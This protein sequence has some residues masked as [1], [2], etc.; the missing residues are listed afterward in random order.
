M[1]KMIET[2]KAIGCAIGQIEKS[3]ALAVRDGALIVATLIDGIF[4]TEVKD[5]EVV[6]QAIAAFTSLADGQRKYL[7][8]HRRLAAIGRKHGLD[9]TAW[10]DCEPAPSAR[11]DLHIVHATAA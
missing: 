9:A 3:A 1:S 5:H 6:E 4:A 11:H 7:E 8:M 2:S 10:G